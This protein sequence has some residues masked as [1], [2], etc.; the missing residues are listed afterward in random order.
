MVEVLLRIPAEVALIKING[1]RIELEI[2]SL[3]FELV[4]R[5]RFGLEMFALLIP[6]FHPSLF[7]F[8]RWMLSRYAMVCIC[9]ALTLA[10]ARVEIFLI[11]QWGTLLKKEFRRSRHEMTLS[12]HLRLFT[13]RSRVSLSKLSLWLDFLDRGLNNLFARILKSYL[14]NFCNVLLYR[15]QRSRNEI[16]LFNGVEILHLICK[17]HLLL[18]LQDL[19]DLH[20]IKILAEVWVLKGW[21]TGSWDLVLLIIQS[22]GYL[23]FIRVD[24]NNLLLW[25][26]F[27]LGMDDFIVLMYRSRRFVWS[28]LDNVN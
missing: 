1:N 4:Q 15:T 11:V 18:K 9:K 3:S 12:T 24:F 7:R 14:I 13:D 6:L 8:L 19:L 17:S 25:R 20:Q 16:L 27:F 28:S 10:I 21:I 2:L 26:S 23:K 5:L 22:L